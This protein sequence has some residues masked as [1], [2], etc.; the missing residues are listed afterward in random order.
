[1]NFAWEALILI[2]SGIVLLRISGR[3]SISQMTLAQTVVMISIGTIIVQPIIETSLWKTLV[4]ASI[5][6][7]ALILMEWFQ[8]KANWVEKFITGK[9]KLVIEDGKLN[10]ENMKKLRLTVDQLEMRMRLHG[11]SSIKDVKN[12]TIEANGQLGYEWH[13]DKKPLTMGDFKKLM[14]IPAAN[15]MNQSEPDKQDNIFEELKNTSHG[16]SSGKLK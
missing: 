3:K 10:I 8:I 11:I 6:T 9:A 13:D 5:F 1:M 16:H 12:A 4:A 7:V 2:I 15:T 14:N